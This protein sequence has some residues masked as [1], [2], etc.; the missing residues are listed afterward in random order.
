MA[1]RSSASASGWP[2]KLPPRDDVRVSPSHRRTRVGLSVTLLTSRS[3]T[4]APTRARRASRRAPAACSGAN[5]HPAPCRSRCGSRMISLSASSAR[6]F[7][8]PICL[9]RDAGARAM[10]R[11]S[12]GRFEPFSASRLIAPAMSATVHEALRLEERERAERGHVLRAV[13]QREALLRLEHDRRDPGLARAPPPPGESA[14]SNVR[15]A[16]ADEHEREV[17]ER[18]EVARGADRA[19]RRDPRMDAALSIATST[20]TSTSRTPECPSASTCARSSIIARTS[21]PPRSGPTPQAVAPDE[22][23][24][25]RR[26][27]RRPG[28]ASR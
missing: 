17:R 5:T 15:L 10:R 21:A 13:D 25:E 11:S 20:S 22:V 27:R 16:F 18:R 4:C 3:S 6:R 26:A 9:A 28:C 8:A 19:L 7:A 1:A 14:P 24:L 23:L 12:N 2:W